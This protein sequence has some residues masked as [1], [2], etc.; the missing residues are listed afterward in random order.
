MDTA[1]CYRIVRTRMIEFAAGLTE[2]QAAK[3]V[4]ALPAW[5]VRDT[6]GHL[7]GVCT[8]VVDGTLTG[9]A[10]DD[11]TAR[12][13]ADRAARNLAE[14]CMEWTARA[15]E[16]EDLL[17]GEKG[18]RYNL[19]TFDAWNHEQDVFGALGLPQFRD[20]PTTPV[21]AAMLTDMF[22]RGWRK[23]ELSPAVR[24]V[25]PTMDTVI[26]IGDPIATL[27]TTDFDLIRMLSGRRTLA[28][29]A[30]MPWT[31]DPTEALDRLHLFT[32]PAEELGE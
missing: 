28:E 12:Q 25:T 26:G 24:L 7:A 5:T 27:H 15:P 9:R 29:M 10:T 32:P 14:V 11:D 13:V 1:E 18:Y 20:C 22:A 8:E 23:G 4:P 21:V 31:G 16:L 6:Y 30:A 19:M 3:P 17:S 2:E